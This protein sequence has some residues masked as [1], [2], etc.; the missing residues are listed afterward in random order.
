MNNY[1][2]VN[3]EIR[4]KNGNGLFESEV[5]CYKNE[6]YKYLI[7]Y[8]IICL[9][10]IIEEFDSDV[11]EYSIK[12]YQQQYYF[13]K[14]YYIVNQPNY[15]SNCY[16][17]ELKKDKEVYRGDTLNSMTTL[18]NH[19]LRESCEKLRLTKPQY[20]NEAE[21]LLDNLKKN[22][23]AEFKNIFCDNDQNKKAIME[24]F[25]EFA[26]LSGTEGNHFLCPMLF[27]SERSGV[28]LDGMYISLD[29]PDLLLEAIYEY[30]INVSDKK[31]ECLFY[32]ITDK[33]YTDI[34]GNNKVWDR[35]SHI[36]KS[37]SNTKKW[38]DK[39]ESDEKENGLLA[40]N[41]FIKANHFD[42]YVKKIKN[43]E[44][45]T[46]GKPIP[47]W[48]RHTLE[49]VLKGLCIFPKDDELLNYLGTIIERIK[50]RKF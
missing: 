43:D 27:N 34:N 14:Q 20:K 12:K 39:F 23:F 46:F 13:L 10:A 21:K 49:N 25:N 26:Y 30:Y 44:D 7:A 17:K 28:R 15:N 42:D 18:F 29:F 36:R 19:F 50:N 11:L 41:N 4:D 37:L 31:L 35:E 24:K 8:Y 40:W 22:S 9:R 48:K 38:L 32:G 2:N 5:L 45:I 1:Y 6:K 47:L 33:P 3:N 16:K